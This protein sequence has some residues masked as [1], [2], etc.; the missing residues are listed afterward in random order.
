VKRKTILI[1]NTN[2]PKITAI[3]PKRDCP[4]YANGRCVFLLLKGCR[5][6]F[7]FEK[8]PNNLNYWAFKI[9]DYYGFEIIS[10]HFFEFCIEWLVKLE[11]ITEL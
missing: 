4:I 11:K 6:N 9:R 7:F 10:N 5:K 2:H 1:L 3:I 8:K